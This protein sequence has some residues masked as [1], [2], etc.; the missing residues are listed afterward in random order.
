MKSIMFHKFT[1]V[2]MEIG[3]TSSLLGVMLMLVSVDVVRPP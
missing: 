1:V 3:G 2:L